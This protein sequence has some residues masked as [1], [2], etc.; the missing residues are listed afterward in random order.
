MSEGKGMLLGLPVRWDEACFAVPAVR[1]LEK[2]GLI[3]GLAL[4]E[5]Q[6][7]FWKTVSGLPQLVFSEK[8]G[9]GN[10]AE[11]VRGKWE[12]SLVWEDGIA[13]KAFAKAKIA[14][15][16]GA[17]RA[18]PGKLLTHPL[19]VTEG[20]TEHRVRL[21]LK[22]CERMGVAVDKPE[23][24]APA[25]FGIPQGIPQGIPPEPGAVLLCPGSDFGLSH[26]WPLDHWQELGEALRST[27]RRI[28]VAGGLGGRGLGKMLA[29]RLGGETVFFHA[30]PLAGALPLLAVHKLTVAADGSLPH[31]AAHAG[32]TCVTLFG[33]NDAVW[34]RPLGKRHKIVKRHVECAPCLSAKCPLDGRCQTELEVARVLA[35]I[36]TLTP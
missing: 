8:S 27:G 5:E 32:S 19:D 12:A 4:R 20:A 23:F 11:E 6:A 26:E 2:S 29:E 7:E 15:R 33:P 3:G 25:E 17:E 28:T 10:L 36:A 21:Y 14:K 34:K 18:V 16:F 22:T 24:F 31:L 9:A 35:A 13:A 1:A 30:A